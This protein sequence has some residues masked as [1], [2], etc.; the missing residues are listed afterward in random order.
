VINEMVAQRI[1]GD[2]QIVVLPNE[3]ESDFS[4]AHDARDSTLQDVCGRVHPSSQTF[5]IGFGARK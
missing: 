3:N 4:D 2:Y 5:E 1:G